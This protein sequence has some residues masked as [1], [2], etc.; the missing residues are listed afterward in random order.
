VLERDGDGAKMVYRLESSP[1]SSCRRLIGPW[2]L[3]RTMSQGALRAVTRIEGLA[4]ERDVAAPRA[5]AAAAR[6]ALRMNALAPRLLAWFDAHGRH[7][8][9]W[10]RDRTPYS[11]WVSEILLQ[12]TQAATVIP[13][14]ERFMQRFRRRGSRRRS[15][16]T[17]CSPHLAASVTTRRARISGA[18]RGSSWKSMAAKCRRRSTRCTR[19][20]YRALDGR[21]DSRAG[22][23]GNG[24]RFSTAT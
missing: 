12:Q 6:H 10:Q 1:I 21:S 14:Y 19:C 24:G 22:T 13:F 3:K 18:P 11:V 23:C 8:F 15:R 2:Y 4:R 9:P 5:C 16:S 17:T 7:D 20:R